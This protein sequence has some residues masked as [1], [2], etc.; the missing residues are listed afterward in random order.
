MYSRICIKNFRGIES[1]DA[2]KQRPINLI[3]GRNNSGKT[4]FLEALLLLGGATNPQFATT[5]GLLRGQRLVGGYPDPVWR[6]LFHNLN[7]G[8][9]VEI[10]GYWSEQRRERELQIFGQ[11]ASAYADSPGSSPAGEE[12]VAATAQDLVIGGLQL[13]SK[14]AAGNPISA[15]A[16]FNPGS[17]N[18]EIRGVFR[19]DVVGTRLLSARATPTPAHDAQHFS[20]LLKKKQDRD[21]IEALRI[22]EP[23]V[24][25]IEVLS[26][27]SG[28]SIYLDIGLDALVPLAVCGEGMVRLFSIILELIASRGGVLLVDEIENGLHYTVMPDL[29]KLLSG[30][31]DRHEVQVFATTHNDDIIRSAL[32]LFAGREGVFGLFRIDKRGDRHVMVGYSEEAMEGVREVHFEVRG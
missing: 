4:T 19:P 16:T 14:D 24:Q 20:S 12:G 17:G 31:V 30:L 25:R 18:I 27:S 6:P 3:M 21:V 10:R 8:T 26:E 28:P 7:P 1:L 22:I 13:R 15:N 5:L 9:P 29:W 2:D 32:E 23:S 11:E